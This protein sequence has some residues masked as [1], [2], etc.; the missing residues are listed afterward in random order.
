[1]SGNSFYQA[2]QQCF[3]RAA[4]RLGVNN[5]LRDRLW[6]PRRKLVVAVPIERDDGTESVFE[7]YRVVHNTDRGPGKGG[8]RFHPA[9]SVEEVTA[10][11]TL[12][13]WKTAML[14][15]PFGGAKGAVACDTKHLSDRE[16]EQVAR[17]YMQEIAP[18]VG[19][20]IDIPAP[21]MYTD[22]RVMGWMMDA[23]DR[24]VGRDVRAV[25]TGKPLALGGTAGRQDAT[26]RGAAIVL[27][28][29]LADRGMKAKGCR[30]CVQGFGNA[31]SLV[32]KILAEEY[33]ARIVS[34][35]DSSGAIYDDRGLP[36]QEVMTLKREEGTVTAHED[37]DKIDVEEQ[38]ALDVDVLIPAAQHGSI[39]ERV[40][41]RVQARVIIE[42]ANGPTTPEADRVLF[43][44]GV[45]V[46]PDILA[47]GGG[48]TVS[49]FEWAQ[50]QQFERWRPERIRENL[51]E[52]MSTAYEEVTTR[53]AE[54]GSDLRSAAYV[55][56]LTRVA[57]AAGAR[58]G[59]R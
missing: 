6:R 14:N 12:M 26:A 50:N 36:I 57:E 56:A 28:H 16:V 22:E 39:D 11:A 23:Y 43:D 1:M 19:P 42:A 49:Y 47:N 53:A 27:A 35:S 10:L 5:G 20:E 38:W 33:G 44:R 8:V 40:A 30:I 55:I 37:A 25:V 18:L 54:D 59:L 41:E 2:V 51:Q 21:D 24:I 29:A 32:S 46:V 58:G 34:V 31:G 45:V 15:L 48:V 52:V 4:D 3:L 13:T 7:G 17:R 9:T